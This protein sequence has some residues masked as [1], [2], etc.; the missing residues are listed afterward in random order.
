MEAFGRPAAHDASA[1]CDENRLLRFPEID[2]YW[3]ISCRKFTTEDML[4]SKP[5][6]IVPNVILLG[7]D[8]YDRVSLLQTLCTERFF[9]PRH[10]LFSS[11]PSPGSQAKVIK[12]RSSYSLIASMQQ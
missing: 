9:C 8:I 1:D 11:V 12:N 3:M 2:S 5:E 10:A 7:H 6:S 4:G